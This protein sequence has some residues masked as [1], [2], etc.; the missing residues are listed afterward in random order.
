[1]PLAMPPTALT[2]L[3]ATAGLAAVAFAL[4]F[5]HA[6]TRARADADAASRAALHT[7]Y[8]D[9]EVLEQPTAPLP[10]WALLETLSDASLDASLDGPVATP[11]PHLGE[12]SA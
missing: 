11:Q 3:V 6:A 9:L 12:Q 2:L 8:L 1:M 4:L 10:A 7:Y 5:L